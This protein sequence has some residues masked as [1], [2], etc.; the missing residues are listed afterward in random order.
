MVLVGRVCSLWEPWATTSATVI[1]PYIVVE[2]GCK[3]QPGQVGVEQA[4][5]W[6]AHLVPG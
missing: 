1:T 2:H 5:G 4:G 6:W 3:G